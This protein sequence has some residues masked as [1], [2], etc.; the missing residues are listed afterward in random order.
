MTDKY[1]A[2]DIANYIVWY[3]NNGDERLGSL[4][5]LKL[6]KILYYT[7][8]SFLKEHNE[9]LFSE[10]F[11]K[12]QYGPVVKDVYHE[13]K[14]IGVSHILHPKL[15]LNENAIAIFGGIKHKYDPSEIEND[16][17]VARVIHDVVDK[18]I[19]KKAFYLVELTH[20]EDAWKNFSIEIMSGI[21]ELT[22]TIDE[23]YQA[24]D[25]I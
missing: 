25:I 3:V 6:Q 15:S 1:T 21:R 22:Y 24:T 2:M 8:T 4:T 18:L 9:L 10:E 20:G 14:T 19:T 12:W 11:Q 16:T 13:F 5:P 7:T 23:L 17:N